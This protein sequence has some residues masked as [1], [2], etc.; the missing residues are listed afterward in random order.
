MNW[1]ILLAKFLF[2]NIY[3]ESIA[4]CALVHQE[5]SSIVNE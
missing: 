3:F 1:N 5:I 2:I 4:H